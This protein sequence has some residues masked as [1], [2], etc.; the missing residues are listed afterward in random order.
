M[1]SSRR[2][3]EETMRIIE[4]RRTLANIALMEVAL[5]PDQPDQWSSSTL[6][7]MDEA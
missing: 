7:F 1:P 4:R 3:F 6:V 5:W 2:W